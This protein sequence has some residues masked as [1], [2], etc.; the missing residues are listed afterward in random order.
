MPF[1]PACTVT[2]SPRIEHD[3]R[4]VA[5][6]LADQDLRPVGLL[7]QHAERLRGAGEIA[8]AFEHIGEGVAIDLDR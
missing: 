7:G 8:G 1:S 5:G 6:L 3:E 4:T 2:S